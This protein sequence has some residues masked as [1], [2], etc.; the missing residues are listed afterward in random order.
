MDH[1]WC[2]AAGIMD[3]SALFCLFPEPH[4]SKESLALIKNWTNNAGSRSS[5]VTC[6]SV[7]ASIRFEILICTPDLMYLLDFGYL[8]HNY[9]TSQIIWSDKFMRQLHPDL[10]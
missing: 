1:G 8:M 5:E 10:H 9:A 6:L 2:G 4:V 7:E 3:E